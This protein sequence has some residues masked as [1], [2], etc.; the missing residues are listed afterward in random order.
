M[1]KIAIILGALLVA[2]AA[3]CSST[4]KNN[5]S[6][7]TTGGTTGGSSAVEAEAKPIYTTTCLACHGDNLQGGLGPA[8]T[9]VGSLYGSVD[10]LKKKIIA[11]ST[12]PGKTTGFSPTMPKDQ[13]DDAKAQKLAE[14]LITKK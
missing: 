8:L 14:W 10:E 13:V 2:T 3:G 11:G 9:K 4:S 1:K 7:G 5:T 12:I 6:G